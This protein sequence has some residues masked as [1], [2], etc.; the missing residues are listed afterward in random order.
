MSPEYK[1][2][3]FVSASTIVVMYYIVTYI[4]PLLQRGV[5]F[6][7]ITIPGLTALTSV[8]AYSGV[9]SLL[10]LFITNSRRIRGILLGSRY[11]EGTWIGKF[12]KDD[13]VPIFTV[14]HFEQTLGTLMIRGAAYFE[15]GK[16]YAKWDSIAEKI[17]ERNGVLHYFY[18]CERDEEKGSYHGVAKFS[19][20]RDHAGASPDVIS[21]YSADLRDEP[22]PGK[23]W[24][25]TEYRI[26]RGLLPFEQTLD[27][28]RKYTHS[29]G[30][31]A[32]KKRRAWFLKR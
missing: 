29:T 22:D 18:S 3:S 9:A 2:H 32:R 19:F 4:V 15:S 28:A 23:R 12:Q 31:K 7:A 11:I 8:G 20:E 10:G 6:P 25:N 27:K 30:V 24:N 26:D 5:P 17:D 1:F 14:E 13:G 21:G 16:R